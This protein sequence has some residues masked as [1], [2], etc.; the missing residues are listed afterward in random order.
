MSLERLYERWAKE[1]EARAQLEG[2]PEGW[3]EGQLEGRLEVWADSLLIVLKGRGLTV[4]ASQRKRMLACTDAAQLASWVRAAGT[5][6][7][8]KELLA[9]PAPSRVR[10]SSKAKASR[11]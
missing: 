4:T 8:V 2:R 6:S 5:A 10:P 11:S 7:N 1:L 9:T 3:L